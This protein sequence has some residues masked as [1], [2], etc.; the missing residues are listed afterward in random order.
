MAR[1]ARPVNPQVSAD[2]DTVKVSCGH[3]GYARLPGRPFHQ[4]QWQMR[5][6]QLV[7][8]DEIS[9]PYQTAQARYHFSSDVVLSIDQGGTSGRALL[10]DGS[11]VQWIT[12][13]GRAHLEDTTWHP[14]FG[15]SVPNKCLVLEMNKGL[16]GLVVYWN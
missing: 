13:H 5:S 15:A 8:L 2:G 12:N 1:R 10:P 9:G 11:T 6:N 3:D 16:S 14:R 4:R 7:I